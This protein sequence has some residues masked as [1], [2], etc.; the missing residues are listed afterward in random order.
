MALKKLV[1]LGLLIISH[2]TQAG[3]VLTDI[4]GKK[5]AFHDLKGK[6]VMINYWASWCQ[7]CVDEIQEFNQFYR[8]EKDRVALFA[9]NYEG[10]SLAEQR[11]L[12]KQYRIRYPSLQKDPRHSLELGDI[13]GVPVTFVFNPRGEFMTALY[14]SQ[15]MDTLREI[16]RRS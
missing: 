2:W 11:H 3:V 7:P 8:I 9:V 4:Q 16:I 14:G 15:T 10:L 12:I 6:W 13:R 5:I 1:F